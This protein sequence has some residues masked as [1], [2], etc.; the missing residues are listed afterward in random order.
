MSPTCLHL[1]EG[2][3]LRTGKRTN[4]SKFSRSTFAKGMGLRR[5]RPGPHKGGRYFY[6]LFAAAQRPYVPGLQGPAT[7][8]D[9]GRA[10]VG[11]S[12]L[13]AGAQVVQSLYHPPFPSRRWLNYYCV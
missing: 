4:F 3:Q 6:D 1:E 2:A 8:W 7:S 11:L 12:L 10:F 5:I 13:T 9:K